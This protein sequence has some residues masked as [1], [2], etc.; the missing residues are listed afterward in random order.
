VP[1]FLLHAAAS[2]SWWL[3]LQP[4]DAG[5]VQLGLQAPLM[6]CDRIAAELGWRPERDA[7]SALTEL[8]AGMADRASDD[9]PPLSG[10]PDLPGRIGGLLK[11]RLPGTG[12]PY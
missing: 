6:S 10:D 3:R 4:I 1:G 2:L 8:V 12:N 7:V 5:W 11:G 9:T